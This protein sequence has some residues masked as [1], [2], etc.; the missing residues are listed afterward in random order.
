[1][2]LAIFFISGLLM[3]VTA[4]SLPQDQNTEDKAHQQW[5]EA[6]YKEATSIRPG[7]TRADLLKLFWPNGGIQTPT[8]QYFTLK[9]CPLIK[10]EV[11]FDKYDSSNR[12]RDDLLR[13]V[14]ISKP[15]LDRMTI[16]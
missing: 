7:M 6:R 11:R 4:H 8:A 13:I 2:K 15:Y 1:M 9:S 10:V 16:D 5:L 12:Q 3:L 14:E